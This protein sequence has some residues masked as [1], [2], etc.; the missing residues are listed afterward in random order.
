[1][2]RIWRHPHSYRKFPVECENHCF[3]AE[4]WSDHRQIGHFQNGRHKVVVKTSNY[5]SRPKNTFK[6][7]IIS[8]LL[9]P[10]LLP[11]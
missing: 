7:Y 6:R 2:S 5:N 1:M 10:N 11:V 8:N 4:I 9:V 3:Q